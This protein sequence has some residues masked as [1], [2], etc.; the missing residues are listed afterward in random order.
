M[1]EIGVEVGLLAEGLDQLADEPVSGFEV[2]G[3]WGVE[4]DRR[5]T[6]N[7]DADRRCD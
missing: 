6:I 2:V 3:Q 7:T 1:L 4:F 5:H